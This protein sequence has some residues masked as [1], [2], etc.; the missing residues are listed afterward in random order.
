MS[1][2]EEDYTQ[3]YRLQVHYSVPSGW[4]NDPN[5]LVYSNG[6][7]HLFYQYYPDGITHGTMNW[8]H[9]KSADLI[10]WENL[11]TAIKANDKG[12]IFSGC[13]VLDTENVTGLV[14]PNSAQTMIAIYTLA[15]YDGV[16][17]QE[18]AYS[19]DDGKFMTNLESV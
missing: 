8:G 7:Y 19:N 14:P 15:G 5:G 11:P 13:C 9:A 6:F 1:A 3:Q 16:Q 18:I 12:E 4:L 17:R 2:K 10:H